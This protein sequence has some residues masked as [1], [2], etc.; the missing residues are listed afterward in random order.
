MF[1]VNQNNFFI[2]IVYIILPIIAFIVRASVDQP[3]IQ[4]LFD[5]TLALLAFACGVSFYLGNRSAKKFVY[6]IG[7]IISVVSLILIVKAVALIFF[8]NKMPLFYFYPLVMELKP[9]IYVVIS[10]WIM[11]VWGVPDTKVFAKYG[12]VLSVLLILTTIVFSIKEGHIVRPSLLSEANYD[13]FLVLLAFIACLLEKPKYFLFYVFLFGAATIITGSR[14]GIASFGLIILSYIVINRKYKYL[15]PAIIFSIAG[16]AMVAQR[17]T[18]V[19]DLNDL[20]RVLMWLSFFS[21]VNDISI[22]EIVFGNF[23]GVPIR[24]TD[25]FIQWYINSM[26]DKINITGLHAFM[27]HGM[28]LRL[29][30]TWGL[31]P[32]IFA[33]FFIASKSMAR[34]KKIMLFFLILFQGTSMGIIYLSVVAAPLIFFIYSGKTNSHDGD[35]SH[36]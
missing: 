27:Y 20:D 5:I 12:A 24:M 29:L 16:G 17:L 33:L 34:D 4:I 30:L 35:I 1:T 32:L 8:S 22:T 3:N 25:P 21:V 9:I 31:I 36:E 7:W 19:S 28:H 10:L 6:I 23:P 15:F 2:A 18:N 14:T 13:G 26:G 11:S